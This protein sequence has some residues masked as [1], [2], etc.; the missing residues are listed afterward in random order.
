MKNHKSTPGTKKNQTPAW[1]QLQKVLIFR[2]HMG[3]TDLLDVQIAQ[4]VNI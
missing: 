3:P 4:T 1:T 2:H